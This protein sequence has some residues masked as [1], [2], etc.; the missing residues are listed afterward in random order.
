M[1]PLPTITDVFRVTFDHDALNG[2][3]TANVLH[4]RAPSAD[5][6]DVGGA[7]DDYLE[8]GSPNAATKMFA[9]VNTSRTCHNLVIM[10]L[11]GLSPGFTF[12][13]TTPTIGAASGQEVP[14]AA[15]LVSTKTAVRGARGRGRTYVGPCCE[16]VMS[17]G[18]VD[19]TPK[20]NMSTG[21]LG[22]ATAMDSAGYEWGIASYVLAD[23]HPIVTID[24]ESPLAT[25]ARRQ[26]QLR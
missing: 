8:S 2:V 25:M 13:L 18:A 1:A 11:D 26:N 22:F 17:A 5:E 20:S 9:V 3:K 15:A 16:D 6:A 24:I 7:I 10:K 14:A 4:I 21:W 23:F 19:A 12:A